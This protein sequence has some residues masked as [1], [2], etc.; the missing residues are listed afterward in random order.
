MEAERWLEV[1]HLYH[2]ALRCDENE[3]TSFLERACAGDHTLRDEVESLLSYAQR[4][5]KVL[6]TPALEVVARALAD[7]LRSQDATHTSRMIDARIAQ[8]RIV[9]KLGS[10]GMGDVYR[11]VRAD[12]QYQK[13]VAIK[14]VRQGLDTEP[15]HARFRQERQILAGFEHENIARLIDGGTTE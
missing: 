4:P 13:Q 1:E 8:Y 15:V 7:D 6:E 3:R 2:A 5:T 11:A 9:G 14:L 10:G 12:D